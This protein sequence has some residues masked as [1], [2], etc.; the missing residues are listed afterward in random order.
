MWTIID[1]DNVIGFYLV[2]C[3]VLLVFNVCTIARS[4]HTARANAR[5]RR[6][7]DKALSKR[8]L[9][10]A[11]SG[12][13]L[14]A[15]DKGQAEHTVLLR[16]LRRTEELMAFNEAL[17]ALAAGEAALVKGY[18]LKN[19]HAFRE[20]AVYYRRKSAMERAFFAYVI[21]CYH[22]PIGAVHDP[23]VEVLLGYMDNSTVYCRENVLGALYALGSAQA[24]EHAFQRLNDQG[25]YH[26]P[27]LLSDG[28]VHFQGDRAE[29]VHR[30]W[31]YRLVWAEYL[32]V[33]VVQLAAQLADDFSALFLPGLTEAGLPLD[34]R[35]ALVRY[36]QRHPAP[37]AKGFLLDCLSE[38]AGQA[39]GLAIAAA[40]ALEKYPANDT[41]KALK[42]ALHSPQWHVRHNAAV[43]LVHLGLDEEALAE[44]RSSGDRYAVEM[45]EYVLER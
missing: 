43:S 30:L 25:F 36:F 41:Q 33:A 4:K 10:L 15:P 45:I 18:M 42:Q 8:L 24:V 26:S 7:W 2:I 32:V 11:R 3:L 35:F 27:R 28:M 9:L 13:P 1:V 12:L 19:Q 23:L 21:A 40:S 16:R 38:S 5:R 34:V 20:L 44:I 6:F 31:R 22:P 14:R 17:G 39:S 37:E 29:L